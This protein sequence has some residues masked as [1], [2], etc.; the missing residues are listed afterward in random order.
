MLL[1]RSHYA[2]IGWLVKSATI[3]KDKDTALTAA[4]LYHIDMDSLQNWVKLSYNATVCRPITKD[5][6]IGILFISH[7][8]LNYLRCRVVPSFGMEAQ[9]IAFF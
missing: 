7:R 5:V 6:N 8:Y 9:L 4:H 3:E 1:C 2:Y